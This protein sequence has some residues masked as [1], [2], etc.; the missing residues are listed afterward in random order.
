MRSAIRSVV[1]CL[2]CAAAGCA[3][4][5]L[6]DAGRPVD[7]GD[8]AIVTPQIAWNQIKSGGRVIWTQN[9]PNVDRID[10]VMG[11]K[12]GMP[13]TALPARSRQGAATYEASMLPDDIEDL[14][15][16]TLQKQGYANVRASSLAPCPL[17]ASQGFCFDLAFA[18]SDGLEMQGKIA[19]LKRSQS[20]D[21]VEFMAPSEYFYG[22]LS[23]AMG[24]I[25][26]SMSRK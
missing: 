5:T 19:A 16:G 9:G 23:P 1:A 13:L 7:V 25:L 26:A 18:T 11:V 17:G 15:V 14:V 22:E 4:V 6:V 21:M 10:F 8:G 24:R 12:P 20:L 3:P 2:A